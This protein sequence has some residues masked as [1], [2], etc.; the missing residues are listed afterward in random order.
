MKCP[1]CQLTPLLGRQS[2]NDAVQYDCERCGRFTLT[3]TAEKVLPGVVQGRAM[4]RPTL[5]HFVRRRQTG[6]ENPEITSD[7]V[8]KVVHELRLPSPAERVDNLILA[9]GNTGKDAGENVEVHPDRFIAV[10]GASSLPS[11]KYL[12]EQLV[13]QGLAEGDW[14]D[15]I[16]GRTTYSGGTPEGRLTLKGWER[17]EELR[18]KGGVG[19]R[20]FIAMEF[21]D[22]ELNEVLEKHFR[23][24]VE[25]TGYELMKLD[26]EPRAGLID[27]RLRVQIKHA[28]FLLADLTHA[29]KGAYWEAGYAEGL[30]K[31]VIYL[32]K[33]AAF[34]DKKTRPHFDTN[35]H[36]TIIWDQ[37]TMPTDMDSLVATVRFSIP[38]ARQ[39]D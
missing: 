12:I 9:L 30:G 2:V 19:T 5:S 25:R 6:E 37:A 7:W 16:S 1:I 3:G 39:S 27:N 11:F 23:P 34:E 26:D 17:Y 36:Q 31:P 32:C 28:R 15:P 21:G 20:A 38:E 22:A 14:V 29:N 24:A 8:Q 4:A 35:H 33:K 18:R 10:A 13:R